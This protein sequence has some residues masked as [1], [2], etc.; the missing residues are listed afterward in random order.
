M[1]RPESD[2]SMLNCPVNAAE[3]DFCDILRATGGFHS[4]ADLIRHALYRLA[5]HLDVPIGQDIFRLRWGTRRRD[6]AST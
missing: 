3:R 6:K 1:P 4:D 2:V 5:K